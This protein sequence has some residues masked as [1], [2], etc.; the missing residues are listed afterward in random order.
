ML[1][2]THLMREPPNGAILIDPRFLQ[3]RVALKFTSL[4]IPKKGSSGEY[5]QETNSLP[6]ETL[7]NKAMT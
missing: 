3:G 6:K 1:Q 2:G 4:D 7:V 5:A